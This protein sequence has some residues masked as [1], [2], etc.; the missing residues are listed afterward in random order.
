VARRTHA[1][2]S[3]QSFGHAMPGAAPE[4]DTSLSDAAPETDTSLP[5]LQIA[6]N[7]V[8]GPP[9]LLCLFVAVRGNVGW[10]YRF[11]E[12]GGHSIAPYVWTMAAALGALWL[13][14]SLLLH[15]VRARR[16]AG[17]LL[18]LAGSALIVLLNS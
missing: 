7:L 15:P 17:G 5:I 1:L 9:F 10:G 16:P 3:S 13:G 11:L 6:V 2:T 4:I 12:G 14:V 8:F 18:V